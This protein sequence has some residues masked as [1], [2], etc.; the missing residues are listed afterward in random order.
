MLF[1]CEVCEYHSLHWK[2]CERKK[3]NGRCFF[4][5]DENNSPVEMNGKNEA[6]KEIILK[7][8]IIKENASR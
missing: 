2:K 1:K 3:C 6:C 8:T 5:R 4:Y 7:G